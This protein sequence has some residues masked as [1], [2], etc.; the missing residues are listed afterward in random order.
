MNKIPFSRFGLFIILFLEVMLSTKS[1]TII[2]EH[3]KVWERVVG[4]RGFTGSR[5]VNAHTMYNNLFEVEEEV[6]TPEF[7]EQKLDNLEESVNV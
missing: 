2:K 4:T 6:E 3:A 7:D 1:L 5:A